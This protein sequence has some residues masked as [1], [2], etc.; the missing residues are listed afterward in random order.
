MRETLVVLMML[1]RI[2]AGEAGVCGQSGEMMVAQVVMARVDAGAPLPVALSAFYGRGE[3]GEQE[4][5][6]AEMVM[7]G[8]VKPGRYFFVLSD[9][10]VAVLG[11]T[12]PPDARIRCAGG[13]HLNFYRRW[14]VQKQTVR[15]WH[16]GLHVRRGRLY[17]R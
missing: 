1:A 15:R 8:R 12:K 4:W 16:E 7:A 9:Q 13:L 3:P 5:K 2:L 6:L 11:V 10:D 17:A 14:P